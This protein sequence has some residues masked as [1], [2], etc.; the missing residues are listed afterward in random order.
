M[1]TDHITDRTINLNAINELKVS[2]VIDKMQDNRGEFH[3]KTKVNINGES[4]TLS[5]T[6]VNNSRVSVS[7][8]KDYS[9]IKGFFQKLVGY[10]KHI[11]IALNTK[12]AEVLKSNKFALATSNLDNFR[13][14]A[15]ESLAKG[16]NTV[17]IADYG[18]SNDRRVVGEFNLVKKVEQEF[19]EQGL[20][21]KFNQIDTYND[22]IGITPN[23]VTIAPEGKVGSNFNGNISKTLDKLKNGKMEIHE[24][25]NISKEKLEAWT[26]FLSQE[27][28]L[29]KLDIVSKLNSYLHMDK[30]TIPEKNT[31]WK[32]EF[33]SDPEKALMNFVMKNLR[34]YMDGVPNEVKQ[35]TYTDVKKYLDIMYI[36]DENKRQAELDKF[37][38]N[39]K[40]WFSPEQQESYNKRFDSIKKSNPELSD[41]EIDN[42]LMGSDI[43]KLGGSQRY[44]NFNNVFSSA[45]FRQTSKLGLEFFNQEKVPVMFQYTNNHNNYMTQ[46]DLQGILNENHNTDGGKDIDRNASF[47]TITNSELRHARRITSRFDNSFEINYTHASNN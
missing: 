9:G 28:N 15:K 29:K 18:K 3:R 45:F 21:I 22:L 14:I 26:D 6:R 30:N 13:K 34:G 2:D 20:K 11:A 23:N 32:A 1:M 8:T 46:N 40:D 33:K 38:G 31:G 10:R 12:L 35:Q 44:I 24:N 17:E 25:N 16:I 27:Q 43:F 7:V 19:S 47:S 36:Q 4:F 41:K 42:M 37:F 39:P 5:F